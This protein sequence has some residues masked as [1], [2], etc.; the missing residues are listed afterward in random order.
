ML[1][2]QKM[3]MGH[4]SYDKANKTELEFTATELLRPPRAIM[5][6]RMYPKDIKVL[7]DQTL[8]FKAKAGEGLHLVYEQMLADTEY[9]EK[10]YVNGFKLN[11]TPEEAKKVRHTIYSEQRYEK[12][13]TVQTPKGS[14]EVSLSGKADLIINGVVQDI[15]YTSVFG[16]IA[17]DKLESFRNQLSI[18]RFLAPDIIV[19]P[20][21]YILAHLHDWNKFRVKEGYPDTAV[22]F[23]KI[24]LKSIEDTEQ[25]VI[26]KIEI[27][28]SGE[29]PQCSD[30]ELWAT[31]SS[32]KYKYYASGDTTKRCTK[33]FDTE[34]EAIQ[35]LQEAN[36]GIIDTV[37]TS[38][39][40]RAC[41]Y[42]SASNVCDQYKALLENPNVNVK[43][44]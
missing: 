28:L 31:P 39:E 6:N 21:G 1:R 30:K 34:D 3:L 36:K 35:R 24:I 32:T 40:V 25:F 4:S 17:P 15:K 8:N 12:K 20:F 44:A 7:S 23:Q 27:L 43:E 18:Y 11:P 9:M 33:I 38:K 2:I 14:C 29:L 26:N 16:Y 13:L 37:I 22:E 42:C 19:V 41:F 5:L 10:T